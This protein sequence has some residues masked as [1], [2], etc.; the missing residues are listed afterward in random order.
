MNTICLE[1]LVVGGDFSL[2]SVLAV[3]CHRDC[4][5]H[6]TGLVKGVGT[7]RA[8]RKARAILDLLAISKSQCEIP[9]AQKLQQLQTTLKKTIDDAG[10]RY[11]PI[12]FKSGS[13]QPCGVLMKL[14]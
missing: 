11:R 10:I 14:V 1:E 2:L 4:A 6:R 8:L 7:T 3:L 13:S 9:K 12:G 5:K